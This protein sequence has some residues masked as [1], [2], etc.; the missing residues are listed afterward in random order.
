MAAMG[1]YCKAYPVGVLRAYEGWSEQ[2]QD[3]KPVSAANNGNQPAVPRTLTDED[4]LFVQENFIVTDSI[5]M[6]EN[7]IFDAVTPEWLQ[8]CKEK[9]AF[10]VP[11]FDEI[12]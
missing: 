7:I 5:F 3:A 6:D 1:R 9:L 10:G 8:F 4:Y 2:S 12:K 11:Q